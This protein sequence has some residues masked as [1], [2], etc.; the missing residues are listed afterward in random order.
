MMMR[1]M[2]SIYNIQPIGEE[3]LLEFC[4]DVTHFVKRFVDSAIIAVMKIITV[5]VC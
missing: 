2:Q 5:M 1:K 4:Q 3:Q